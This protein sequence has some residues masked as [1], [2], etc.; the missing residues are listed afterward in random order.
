ML[1]S[2]LKYILS[3]AIAAFF[4][5]LA[6]KDFTAAQ[7]EELLLTLR[8]VNYWWI[9]ATFAVLM[10]SNI[11][12]AWRWGMLLSTVKARISLKNLFN[13]TMIGYAVNQVLPRVGEV[14]KIF[15]L[16][17]RE[18]IDGKKVIASVVIER[19]LDLLT[20]AG[21]LAA[22][23]F[24]FRQKLNEAFEEA[25]GKIWLF[26]FSLGGFESEGVRVTIEHAAY[27]M[28]LAS[29]LLLVMFALL[30]LFPEQVSRMA[31][32]IVRRF[33]EKAARWLAEAL[34]AFVEGA[35]A[36]RNPAKYAEIIGSSLAIWVCYIF[37]TLLP[38]YAMNIDVK[39][40]LG[41][42]EA[43]TTMSISA[44]GQLITPA[45][46]GT[47]QYACT[48]A[49]EKIFDVSLVDASSFALLTFSVQ[50]LTFGL[51]GLAC[52]V[53]QSR[54]GITPVQTIKAVQPAQPD[55]SA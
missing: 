47:Y 22:S 23:A 26:R 49:L 1:K 53:W 48:K 3:A 25:F 50:L 5:W 52:Y 46:A 13:A 8:G 30:S 31:E 19:I 40:G 44:F 28:L 10:L 6:F 18:H 21:V 43:M 32:R 37:G 9:A 7:F 51:A 27:A 54:E 39:Y 16:A 15:N 4:F 2:S 12:R 42:L 20:F 14:T 11:I 33:S 17:K 24:L 38:F 41:L 45:G 36:L 29:M 35:A 55:L 34:K